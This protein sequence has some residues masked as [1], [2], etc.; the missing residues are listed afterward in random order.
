MIEFP[1]NNINLDLWNDFNNS[2]N[3]KHFT[4]DSK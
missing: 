4:R 1:A 2:Y 3:L